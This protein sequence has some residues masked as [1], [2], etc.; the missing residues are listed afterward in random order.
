MNQKIKTKNSGDLKFYFIG[1]SSGG[2]GLL[3]YLLKNNLKPAAAVILKEDKHEI[4]KHSIQIASILKKVK[5]PFQIKKSLSESDYNFIKNAGLDF[6]IVFGW[7]T[8]I[9]YDFNKEPGFYAAHQSLL[10]KYRGFAPVQWAII[11]GE[12]ETGVTL[13]KINNGEADS[14]DIVYQKKVKIEDDDF[15]NNVSIKCTDAAITIYTEFF[16]NYGKGTVKFKKQNESKATYTCKRIPEDGRIDW[17][18]SSSEIYNLIRGVSFPSPGAFC[19]FKNERYIITGASKGVYDNR[20]F[21]GRIPGRVYKISHEGIE[22]LCGKG[23]LFIKSW[24]LSG[25]E[26][27]FNPSET[28]TSIKETLS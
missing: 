26:N 25:N 24:K 23:T 2:Y 7:R 1:G 14:G 28:V 17:N 10:P 3:K 15:F 11:N 18:K 27:S 19:F 22:V 16:F 20:I 5:V 4:E 21:T 8:L 6:V 12:K 13:F 9:K